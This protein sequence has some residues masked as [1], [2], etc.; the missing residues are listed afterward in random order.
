MQSCSNSWTCRSCSI[1]RF[2]MMMHFNHKEEASDSIKCFLGQI[3]K[4]LN[5]IA[6][7]MIDEECW[8]FP[9]LIYYY[10]WSFPLF[11][12]LWVIQS[13]IMRDSNPSMDQKKRKVTHSLMDRKLPLHENPFTKTFQKKLFTGCTKKKL[14]NKSF[15]KS[16]GDVAGCWKKRS[17]LVHSSSFSRVLHKTDIFVCGKRCFYLI[18]W[19]LSMHTCILRE[20]SDKIEWKKL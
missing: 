12:F 2:A 11:L 17:A 8:N 18:R 4:K 3:L 16:F 13:V 19:C 5:L 10:C 6:F 14:K 1:Y 20:F 15:W 9:V 7:S